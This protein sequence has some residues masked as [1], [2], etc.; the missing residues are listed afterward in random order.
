MLHD[1]LICEKVISYI[2][3]LG[4][5]YSNTER[6]QVRAP[7]NVVYQMYLLMWNKCLCTS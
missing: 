5:L 3:E 1:T 4:N 2:S 6:K 7:G